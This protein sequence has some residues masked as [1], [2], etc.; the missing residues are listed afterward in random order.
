MAKSTPQWFNVPGE[1]WFIVSGEGGSMLVA[2]DKP[3][4]VFGN[5]I[6]NCITHKKISTEGIHTILK[7]SILPRSSLQTDTFY[8]TDFFFTHI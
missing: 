3:V 6:E 7:G 8:P 5:V 2:I 1:G 4:N